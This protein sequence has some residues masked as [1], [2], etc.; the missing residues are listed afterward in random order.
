MTRLAVMRPPDKMDESVEVARSAGFEPVCASPLLIVPNEDRRLK[1]F[2]EELVTGKVDMMVLTSSTGVNAL[3]A[4]T[5]QLLDPRELV[6]LLEGVT[7]VAIGPLTAQAMER[8]GMHVSFVPS[9]Y[10]SEG[11]ASQL[12]QLSVKGK[13]IFVLRSDHGEMVLIEALEEEGAKVTEVTVYRLVKQTDTPQMNSMVRE[14]LAGSIDVYA[15]T[16]SLSAVSF[17]ESACRHASLEEVVK[18]INGKVVAAVG[19]PTKRRLEENGIH[20]DVVPAN[21]TFEEMLR[22]LRTYM[23]KGR[24]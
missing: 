22:A 15:F 1:T 24:S 2:L 7:T 19:M 20:V 6:E 17:I 16:S 10:S 5:E 9:V 8:R 4:L 18:A 14:C 13:N 21:A 23:D 11:L 3:L 12:D